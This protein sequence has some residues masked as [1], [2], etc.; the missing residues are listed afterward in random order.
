MYGRWIEERTH[1]TSLY[2]GRLLS[3]LRDCFRLGSGSMSRQH[4]LA[5]TGVRRRLRVHDRDV[6]IVVQWL[7][8]PRR[9]VSINDT[10]KTRWLTSALALPRDLHGAPSS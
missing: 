6:N 8:Q 1:S 2:T 5:D 7:G 4:C 3:A 9:C 10:V